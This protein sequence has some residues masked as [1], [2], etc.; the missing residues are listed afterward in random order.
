MPPALEQTHELKKS[1]ALRGNEAMRPRFATKLG[2]RG[3]QKMRLRPIARLWLVGPAASRIPGSTTKSHRLL[4]LGVAALVAYPF[5]ALP[6]A[7]A[8]SQVTPQTLRPAAPS[9]PGSLDLSGGARLQTPAGTAR[10][11][12][13]VGRLRIEGAFAG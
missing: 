1:G 8:P 11:S 10:L 5:A 7:V 2:K 9:P 3:K 13:I 12:F 4:P 6:Q